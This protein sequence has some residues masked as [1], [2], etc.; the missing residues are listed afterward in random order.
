[1][2]FRRTSCWLANRTAV[3]WLMVLLIAGGLSRAQASAS[4]VAQATPVQYSPSPFTPGAPAPNPFEPP[5]PGA[6]HYAGPIR[7]YTD[8]D[9][10]QALWH[11][12]ASDSFIASPAGIH[13]QVRQGVAILTGW[14]NTR[15][16]L[17]RAETDAYAAG[18]NDVINRLKVRYP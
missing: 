1:M 7:V 11:D 15:Q 5:P 8:A 4:P 3:K 18:A 6:N 13:I 16:E 2:N 10:R 12:L 17:S 9:I 14:V